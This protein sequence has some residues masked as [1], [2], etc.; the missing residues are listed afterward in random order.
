MKRYFFLVTLVFLLFG[1]KEYEVIYVNSE[2]NENDLAIIKATIGNDKN[3]LTFVDVYNNDSVSVASDNKIIF[4][5][6]ISN[7]DV[8]GSARGVVF[9]RNTDLLKIE[10]NNK[11]KIEIENIPEYRFIY[12]YKEKDSYTVKYQKKAIVF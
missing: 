11:K 10:I 1:C 12:L 2:P 3:L 5:D 7:D 6:L 9:D 8:S 4:K